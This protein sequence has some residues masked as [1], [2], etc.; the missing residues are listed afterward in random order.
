MNDLVVVVLLVG[1]VAGIVASLVTFSSEK[2]KR[3][4]ASV[5]AQTPLPAWVAYA[6]LAVLVVAWPAVY[7]VAGVQRLA[8]RLGGGGW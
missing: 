1:W 4:V 6:F 2:G 8:G 7:V 5:T 3:R